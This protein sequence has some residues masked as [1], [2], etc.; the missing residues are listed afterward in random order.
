MGTDRAED[1]NQAGITMDVPEKI[2]ADE[3]PDLISGNPPTI[4]N[5]HPILQPPV[6]QVP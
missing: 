3:K 4:K 6:N 5:K 2:L 1:D